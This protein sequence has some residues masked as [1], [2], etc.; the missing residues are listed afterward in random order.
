[1][2]KD[3][4]YA[5]ARIRGR[6]L[7]L[8]GGPVMEQLLACKTCEEALRFLAD[9]GWGNPDKAL[10]AENLLEEE[11]AAGRI[12][13]YFVGSDGHVIRSESDYAVQIPLTLLKKTE[14]V[15][16]ICSA[17]IT[18]GALTAALKSGYIHELI[19]PENIV[20]KIL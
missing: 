10:T 16:G 18:P 20:K 13:N 4:T 9:K 1:M 14:H 8:F 5:V 19:A 2:G 7:A 15:V 12:L 11:K 17:S 6:E 3:Y